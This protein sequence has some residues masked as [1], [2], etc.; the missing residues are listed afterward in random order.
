MSATTLGRVQVT[1]RGRRWLESGHPWLYANDVASESAEP[2][3]LVRVEQLARERV[4][5]LAAGRH[6]VDAREVAAVRE[7]E[8]HVADAAPVRVL[9]GRR[10]RVEADRARRDGDLRAL[11]TGA[12]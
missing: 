9:D 7:R 11:A 2:G 4:V 3:E 6:A 12:T 8:P 10:H 5:F 1:G